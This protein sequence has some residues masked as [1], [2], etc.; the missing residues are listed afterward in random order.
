MTE[1][2]DQLAIRFKE[3]LPPGWSYPICVELLSAALGDVPHSA[4]RPLWF[5]H[6]EALRLKDRRLRKDHDLPLAVLESE[7]TLHFVGPPQPTRPVWTLRVSSVPSSLKSFAKS[8]I[9]REA[10]P[11][12]RADR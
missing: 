8:C 12:L 7:F 3:H 4:P 5:A 1:A 10:L 11:R 2:T 6:S 9:V